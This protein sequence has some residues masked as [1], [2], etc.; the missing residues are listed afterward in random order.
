MSDRIPTTTTH[1]SGPCCRRDRRTRQPVSNAGFAG[2]DACAC[3]CHALAIARPRGTS[4]NLADHALG[5]P[6]SRERD[7]TFFYRHVRSPCIRAMAC[8]Y[9]AGMV[10]ALAVSS[11]TSSL[12]SGDCGSQFDRH[13]VKADWLHSVL[14]DCHRFFMRASNL[15]PITP[16][17][18]GNRGRVP[19]FV[20][21][22][23]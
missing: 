14:P 1:Q 21:K 4:C 18:D 16:P 20:T 2:T 3:P 23:S 11:C 12:A 17:A 22:G 5:H 19:E 6:N 13:E 8:S 7:P 9:R 10:V 15:Q